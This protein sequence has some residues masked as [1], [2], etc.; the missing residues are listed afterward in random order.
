MVQIYLE[1]CDVKNVFNW[2]KEKTTQ[3]NNHKVET[4]IRTIC[5]VSEN[6][7]NWIGI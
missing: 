3:E 6:K 1:R 4:N 2:R 7:Y 5:K